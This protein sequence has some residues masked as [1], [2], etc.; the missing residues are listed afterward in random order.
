MAL[1]READAFLGGFVAGVLF[2]SWL[3][4]WVVSALSRWSSSPAAQGRASR[5]HTPPRR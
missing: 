3:A 2:A 5:P 1:T 4:W